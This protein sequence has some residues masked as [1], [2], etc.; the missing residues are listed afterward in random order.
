VARLEHDVLEAVLQAPDVVP[1]SFDTLDGD[2]FQTPEFRAIHDAVRAAGGVG[3][4]ATVG[5]P[6]KWLEQVRDSAAGVVA[7][8][9]TELAV[10]PL[11]ISEG[12]SSSGIPGEEVDRRRDYVEGVVARLMEVV[13]GRQIGEVRARLGRLGATGDASE[14]AELQLRMQALDAQRRNLRRDS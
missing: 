6:A 14:Q 4:A 9:V 5:G 3:A 7:G 10:T 13:V 11:P 12:T 8:M 2:A 1:A